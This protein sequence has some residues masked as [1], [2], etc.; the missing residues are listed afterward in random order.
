[1]CARASRQQHC[2]RHNFKFDLWIKARFRFVV[3]KHWHEGSEHPRRNHWLDYCNRYFCDIGLCRLLP[4][5]L[6]DDLLLSKRPLTT[7]PREAHRRW[8]ENFDLGATQQATMDKRAVARLTPYHG[9]S[10][11]WTD[12]NR[13]WFSHDNLPCGV[14]ARKAAPRGRNMRR[15]LKPP[16]PL[17]LLPSERDH[18][19][20]KRDNNL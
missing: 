12:L 1:M 7:S 3:F 19:L 15:R 6:T 16:A 20:H 9:N 14:T 2:F 18:C 4:S 17:G 13:F 5:Q 10:A 11:Y 8:G